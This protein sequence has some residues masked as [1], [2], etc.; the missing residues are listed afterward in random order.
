[1]E[2]GLEVLRN[3]TV[4]SPKTRDQLDKAQHAH[5]AALGHVHADVHAL[6]EAQVAKAAEDAEKAQIATTETTKE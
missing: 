3:V 2:D 4:R 5:A 6:A 1:M